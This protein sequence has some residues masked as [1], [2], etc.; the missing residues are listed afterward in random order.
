MRQR[1][2]DVQA[3]VLHLA[4]APAVWGMALG[5]AAARTFG[6]MPIPLLGL[7]I[8]L[9]LWVMVMRIAVELLRHAAV[10]GEDAPEAD[11]FNITG[12][13]G[14]RQF[15][16]LA[17]MALLAALAFRQ[18]EAALAAVFVL[19]M[20]CVYPAVALAIALDEPESVAINPLV[21]MRL[22]RTVG[23]DYLVSLGLIGSA[24]L[25][26]IALPG[27]LAGLM[28]IAL[29]EIVVH[30]LAHLALLL[31]Y[32]ALGRTLWL[33]RERLGW[34]PSEIRPTLPRPKHPDELPLFEARQA[35]AENRRDEA[36]A[37]LQR[38][39]EQRGLELE[40]HALLRKCL[41]ERGDRA[42]IAAHAEVY[43]RVLL[44]RERWLDALHF[45]QAEF[46]ERM[47]EILPADLLPELIAAL[48][49]QGEDARWIVPLVQDLARRRRGWRGIAPLALR[50]A[51]LIGDD[52][53]QQR[54]RR[55][56]LQLAAERAANPEQL[57]QARAALD[58]LPPET[59]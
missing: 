16:L 39:L 18:L 21:W 46:P 52:P 58:A 3:Y 29:R 44:A 55:E 5:L 35:L 33:H 6:L 19:A 50:A 37:I 2:R 4:R 22:W 53:A 51:Q 40:G 24:A 9:G 14:W 31:A 54:V 38:S 49:D 15:L 36:I 10:G 28:P 41:L 48:P 59:R 57:A 25:A 12:R 17:L 27:L 13:H 7:L 34:T 32:A 47:P 26:M 43:L 20:L 45:A 8:D 56:L 42:A 1:E 30:F 23:T 11:D